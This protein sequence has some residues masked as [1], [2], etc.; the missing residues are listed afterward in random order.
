[1]KLDAA[2]V[3]EYLKRG[4]K[5]CERG[6]K[7]ITL[8]TS[9][10]N[11]EHHQKT[12]E[13][14]E[15]RLLDFPD[16]SGTDEDFAI[17]GPQCK[18]ILDRMQ[19]FKDHLYVGED[20]QM[21]NL[22]R[23]DLFAAKL[24]NKL[25]CKI[26]RKEAFTF[27]LLFLD[28]RTLHLLRHLDHKN[29][30]RKKASVTSVWSAVLPDLVWVE[31]LSRFA[32]VR[33]S[34]IGYTRLVAGEYSE[35]TMTY[36]ASFHTRIDN[37][38]SKDHYRNAKNYR[39]LNLSEC[40]K[41]QQCRSVPVWTKDSPEIQVNC[42]VKP[43]YF[44][45]CAFLSSFAWCVSRWRIRFR[46]SRRQVIELVYLSSV[47][48]SVLPFVWLTEELCEEDPGS[49]IEELE[50]KSTIKFWHEK[51]CEKSGRSSGIGGNYTRHQVCLSHHPGMESSSNTIFTQQSERRLDDQIDIL[52][53][54]IDGL[55][56]S[57]LQQ[58]GP[59][60]LEKMRRS[61]SFVGELNSLK[62]LPLAALVGL[63][64]IRTCFREALYGECPSAEPHGV[65][66]ANLGCN[67]FQL[68]QKFVQG[69]NEYFDQPR[70][71]FF[72]GDHVLC[73]AEGVHAYPE[74]LKWDVFFP[75]M[76]LYQFAIDK[77]TRTVIVERK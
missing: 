12:K 22:L 63:F 30:I 67:T 18:D 40:Y 14:L 39:E 65:A 32:L 60:I 8:G 49:Y 58:D 68:E 19:E 37:L 38:L 29:D 13:E 76:E 56:D 15:D 54:I 11:Y 62:I 59:L 1:M 66:L 5:D 69:L 75:E 6:A 41:L 53:E 10:Q 7:Q 28:P 72:H 43:M 2:V 17:L 61:I 45:P 50:T 31:D 47:Q 33:L 20:K 77:T 27:S 57:S 55:A 42:I 35:R 21:T 16:R 4:D 3:C 34:A 74:R 26:N 48:S 71:Y 51:I 9:T 23:H 64:D 24:N 44:D 73:M 46:L 36:V 25:G 70:E 52:Q